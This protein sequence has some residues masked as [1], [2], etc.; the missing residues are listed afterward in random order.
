M[1]KTFSTKNFILIN[2]FLPDAKRILVLRILFFYHL[3][4]I[5]IYIGILRSRLFHAGQIEYDP[6]GRTLD[7]TS[8]KSSEKFFAHGTKIPKNR[9]KFLLH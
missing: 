8:D 3:S 6:S 5:Y 2:V 7:E 1:Q 9:P 4:A